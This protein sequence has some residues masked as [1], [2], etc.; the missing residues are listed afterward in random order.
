L[1]LHNCYNTQLSIINSRQLPHTLGGTTLPAGSPEKVRQRAPCVH[2]CRAGRKQAVPVPHGRSPLIDQ[3]NS[4]R[5]LP[6]TQR[7]HA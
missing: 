6:S 3:C 5:T 1:L 4:R 2:N 7:L